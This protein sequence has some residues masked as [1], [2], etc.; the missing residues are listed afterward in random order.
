MVALKGGVL[1]NVTLSVEPSSQ[2]YV[3]YV[4]PVLTAGQGVAHAASE[5]RAKTIAT[6][7]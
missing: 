1:M 7:M 3:A 4:G 2:R 6:R 5:S